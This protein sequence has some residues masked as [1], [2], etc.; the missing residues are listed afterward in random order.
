VQ[1]EL[2]R[3]HPGALEKDCVRYQNG[4]RDGLAEKVI[5]SGE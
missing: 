2:S 5:G 4:F 3:N 1:N